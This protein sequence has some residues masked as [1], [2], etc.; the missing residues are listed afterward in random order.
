MTV[1]TGAF[2]ARRNGK[3]FITG[4]SQ[5]FPKSM[6]ILKTG[7]QPAVEAELI[8]Q[9]VSGE[10]QWSETAASEVEKRTVTL[11]GKQYV[12]TRHDDSTF[13]LPPELLRWKGYGTALK[14]AFEPILVYRKPFSEPTAA[15]QVLAT[16]TG[17]L[18]IDATRVRGQ[19]QMPG[20]RRVVRRFDAKG[21]KPE[22]EPPPPP[23]EGG[24]WPSNLVL[25]HHPD[26]KQMGTVLAQAPVI[27]RFDDGMKPFGEG[28]G[29]PYT[30][31]GGG[32][33]EVPVYECAD[34]C[35]VKAMD[36]QSGERKTTWIAPEHQNNRGGEI[37]GALQHPGDQGYNDA[38][39]ASRFFPQF[40]CVPECPVRMLDE[41]SGERKTSDHGSVTRSQQWSGFHGGLGVSGIPEVAYGD[42]GGAS[43]FFP[44][45]EGQEP[46]AAP[47]LYTGKA[48]K[49]ETTLD[50]QVA[51]PHPTK[52]PLALMEWLVKLVCPKGGTVLDPYAGSG[53]TLV[54]A[55]MND[56]NFI[57]IEKDPVYHEVATKRVGYVHERAELERS[58]KRNA[59][60]AES[61]EQD[62]DLYAF[63]R[64]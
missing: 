16:G 32:T 44:S 58:A 39:G 38:G 56:M 31:S 7:I 2:V 9:G 28:A 49:R 5:G 64:K 46:P 54:A 30:S 13:R 34:G 62:D 36:E 59:L 47:F 50:G 40:E 55:T 29:H 18:N 51:N 20:S 19:A 12:V 53:S 33:E 17:A 43:R 21:D 26:C 35:P 25:C 14:P 42:A 37:L 63:L 1:P 3:V 8:K 27:N 4:N 24:R 15:R 45:F 61:L 22:L 23:H 60:E 41:Q 57:G 52:K 6:N 10:I 48:S 11:Y